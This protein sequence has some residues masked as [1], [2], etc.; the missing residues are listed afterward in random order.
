VKWNR[1]R[2]SSE[3]HTDYVALVV[4]DHTSHYQIKHTFHSLEALLDHM[5]QVVNL[6]AA[7]L[8]F[9][10]CCTETSNSEHSWALCFWKLLELFMFSH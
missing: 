6:E 1:E 4:G 5:A 10:L 8:T 2:D 7:P 9:P 3:I